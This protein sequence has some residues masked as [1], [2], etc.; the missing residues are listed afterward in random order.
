MIL[1]Q[2]LRVEKFIWGQGSPSLLDPSP[3]GEACRRR[4]MAPM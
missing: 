4:G 1:R 3:R 2:C